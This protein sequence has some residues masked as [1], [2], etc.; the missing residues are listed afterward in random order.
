MLRL[1]GAGSVDEEAG[2]ASV[3]ERDAPAAGSGVISIGALQ[4]VAALAEDADFAPLEPCDRDHL[5]HGFG[6]LGLDDERMRQVGPDA[7]LDAQLGK[8]GCGRLAV[9]AARHDP[10]SEPGDEDHRRGEMRLGHLV[11]VQPSWDGGSRKTKSGRRSAIRR[12]SSV[13]ERTPSTASRNPRSRSCRRRRTPASSRSASM[14][15]W[16]IQASSPGFT[17]CRRASAATSKSRAASRS[18]CSGT[19]S[20]AGPVCWASV[21]AAAMTERGA[22]S[23]GRGSASYPRSTRSMRSIT[24]CSATPGPAGCTAG[25]VETPLMTADFKLSP[26]LVLCSA[27]FPRSPVTPSHRASDESVSLVCRH[28]SASPRPPL[29]DSP[30]TSSIPSPEESDAARPDPGSSGSP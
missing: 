26:T 25:S 20:T 4:R 15:L 19:R 13:G 18:R 3:V 10:A 1:Q 5:V 6:E 2:E 29:R 27:L 9:D 30:L 12:R 21:R 7:V 16:M 28:H 8:R 14:S 17:R 11:L 23:A 24:G 22:T